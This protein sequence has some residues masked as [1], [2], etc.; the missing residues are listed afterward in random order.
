MPWPQGSSTGSG[1]PE[2]RPARWRREVAT[3]TAVTPRRATHSEKSRIVRAGGDGWGGKL[4]L[5]L[6][7][8]AQVVEES[9]R[10][11][12]CAR[13]FY[14]SLWGRSLSLVAKG[15]CFVALGAGQGAQQRPHPGKCQG[16]GCWSISGFLWPGLG[17]EGQLGIRS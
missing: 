3:A 12:E 8:R 5:S 9:A 11:S 4:Q 17:L 10:V 6:G 2:E 13:K 15:T 7:N 1:E 14:R 16:L